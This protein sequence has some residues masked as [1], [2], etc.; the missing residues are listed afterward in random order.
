VTGRDQRLA[1]Q[2]AARQERAEAE[3]LEE[4]QAAA[5]AMMDARE[6]NDATLLAMAARRA[7]RVDPRLLPERW[8]TWVMAVREAQ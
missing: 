2:A 3:A 6:L 1:L 4:V 7:C 8:A 5:A